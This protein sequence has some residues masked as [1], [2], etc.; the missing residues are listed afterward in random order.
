MR[1]Q[2]LGGG[3]AVR[4]QPLPA[5]VVACGVLVGWCAE[6]VGGHSKNFLCENLIISTQK[7]LYNAGS[8]KSKVKIFKK[9]AEATARGE[10]KFDGPG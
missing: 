7:P 10:S 4:Y 2:A 6:R 3:D 5:V 9:V 8:K 1:R